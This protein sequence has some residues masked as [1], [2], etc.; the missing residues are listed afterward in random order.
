LPLTQSGLTRLLSS[1]FADGDGNIASANPLRGA[2][3]GAGL[4]A[5][6]QTIVFQ[7][8]TAFETLSIA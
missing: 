3:L 5:V 4:S 1:T 6:R 7:S 8:P 2:F